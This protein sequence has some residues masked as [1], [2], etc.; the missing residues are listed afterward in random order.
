V[1]PKNGKNR[2]A[3][4]P[5]TAFDMLKGCFLE[6]GKLVFPSA[7]GKPLRAIP[8]PFRR[9][10]K[11]LGFNAGMADPRNQ[12]VFHTLRHTFA[13]WLVQK[14]QSLFIVSELLGHSSLTMTKRYAQ[15]SPE[16]RS[17]ATQVLNAFI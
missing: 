6:P 10:V 2:S 9:I 14:D 17:V 5:E 4:I 12:V 16:R 3:Y 13:S 15:L 7:L 1:D 8:K 11:K